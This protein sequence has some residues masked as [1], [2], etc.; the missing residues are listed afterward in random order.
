MD[1]NSK[2]LETLEANKQ[3]HMTAQE[4]VWLVPDDCKVT[5]ANFKRA[6]LALGLLGGGDTSSLPAGYTRVEYLQ[7]DRK[8]YVRLGLRVENLNTKIKYYSIW[9]TVSGNGGGVF[10]VVNLT[11][12]E[13]YQHGT[14][15]GGSGDWAYWA[16]V[17]I[18]GVNI[19]AGAWKYTNKEDTTEINLQEAYVKGGT[20]VK[21][22]P[23]T[24]YQYPDNEP[25]L[26]AE[27][28]VSGNAAFGFIQ[29]CAEIKL[30]DFEA[31]YAGVPAS[32]LIP[33]LASTGVPCLYDTVRKK[34]FF[35]S[36]SGQF[37]AG[38]KD[39]AQLRT[40]LRK[41]PDLTGQ[42]M[43]TLTLSIPAEANTPE[44]QELL[45]TTETHK[46]WEL[47]IQERAAEVATYS[48]SR[49][50]KVVW[51]R[52]VREENGS[53]VDADGSRWQA[54]WCSAIYSPRG[55]DPTLHGYEPF[56]SVEQAV[57]AWGLVPYEYP[58]QE[59]LTE[60]E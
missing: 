7:T 60:T 46:N 33:A 40:V 8:Q 39:A 48:L 19:R 25:I 22:L 9:G 18:K 15:K 50:R 24:S 57:E 32:K 35:N 59:L 45:D 56:D 26:F 10:T 37:I 54:E 29:H 20:Q 31:N 4:S 55:N 30:Y 6:A 13:I 52:K 14:Y 51:V 16:R 2:L 36:G 53:Y 42:D 27:N 41:L 3:K 38:I 1:A 12:G 28:N 11:S 17:C 44:M 47:T 43:G 21:N 34:A 5:K 58:E 23:D 49:V